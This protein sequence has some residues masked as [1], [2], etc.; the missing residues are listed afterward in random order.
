[1]H[2]EQNHDEWLAEDLKSLDQGR[3]VIDRPL[4]S[5][6]ALV[7]SQY[8]WIYHYSPLMLLGYIAVLEGMPPTSESLDDLLVRTSL[9]AQ[10]LRTA[11]KHA[12]LDLIHAADLDEFLNRL[13]LTDLDCANVIHSSIVTIRHLVDIFDELLVT[14]NGN[15]L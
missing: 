4:D 11:Y 2:E 3:K 14:M 6:A 5:V 12:T 10:C 7:G 9:P 8:Y 13:P 15:A 1:M